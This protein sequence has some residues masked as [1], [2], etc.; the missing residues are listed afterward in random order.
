MNLRPYQEQVIRDYDR[1]LAVGKRR[2]ILVC[3][4]G[5]GKTVIA[6]AIIRRL[7]EK[8]RGVLV[9]VHRR[10]II[11]QTSDK[12]HAHG[13]PHGIIMAGEQNRPL[14]F[15]QVASIQTLWSRA[16]Q[17]ENM[18]L[19]QAELLMIDEAHHCPANTYRKIIDAY[20]KRG[21]AGTDGDA[22][23]G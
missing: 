13:V 21:P 19:P 3:P 6:A 8:R 23:P 12:L 5:G 4:T 9:L 16:I 22:M 2:I 14:E 15:V 7:H 1:A 18:A 20:P 11:G 17:R 10:E